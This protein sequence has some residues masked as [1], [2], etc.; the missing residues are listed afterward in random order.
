MKD[1]LKTLREPLTGRT[2]FVGIGN[3]DLAD[4]AFGVR[5]AEELEKA[6]VPDVTV[7][8]TAPENCIGKIARGGFDHVVFL[9]AVSAGAKPGSFLFMN[10]SDLK[11][12][13]PQISTHKFALG[14]LA[15]LIESD[16]ATKV[17]LI[18]VEP[19]SV[20]MYEPMTVKVEQTLHLLRDMLLQLIDQKKECSGVT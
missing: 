6:G 1:L 12:K 4:D 19:E 2:A 20:A 8:H 3:P 10:A 14:T 16:S 15:R 7:A 18:G 9:D 5:L 11:S 13:F 17:W